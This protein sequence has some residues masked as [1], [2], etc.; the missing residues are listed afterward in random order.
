MCTTQRRGAPF[1][2]TDCAATRWAT[3][4]PWLNPKIAS[5]G[6][7]FWSASWTA[8]QASSRP[9]YLRQ[10]SC[11]PSGSPHCLKT[12][13]GKNCFMVLT[14]FA[15]IGLASSHVMQPSAKTNSTFSPAFLTSGPSCVLMTF[16][17]EAVPCK[18]KTLIFREVG[19]GGGLSVNTPAVRPSSASLGWNT[20][21]GSMRILSLSLMLTHPVSGP[22]PVSLVKDRRSPTTSSCRTREPVA[23]RLAASGELVS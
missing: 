2:S 1:P 19:A 17:V 15:T 6:A 10:P 5:M 23:R 3:L 9:S 12:S 11:S 13:F 4:L 7:S 20:G 21:A 18:H 16:G 8:L 22:S 14:C